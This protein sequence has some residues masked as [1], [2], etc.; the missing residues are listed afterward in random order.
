MMETPREN[1]ELAKG[2]AIRAARVV[3]VLRSGA[4]TDEQWNEVADM[5]CEHHDEYPGQFKTLGELLEEREGE[6]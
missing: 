4:L 2:R 5:L 3:A 1:V 6:H